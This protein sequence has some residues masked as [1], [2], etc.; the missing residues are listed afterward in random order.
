[1]VVGKWWHQRRGGAKNGLLLTPTLY[2]STL[3]LWDYSKGKV[4]F[5]HTAGLAFCVPAPGNRLR[6]G[7]AD[8]GVEARETKSLSLA[9]KRR[10][11]SFDTQVWYN[12]L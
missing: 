2:F 6:G 8:P 3:K 9:F 10:L 4:S 1:M 11:K 7:A 5:R 12:S